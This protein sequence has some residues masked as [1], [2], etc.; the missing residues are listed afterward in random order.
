MSIVKDNRP[1]SVDEREMELIVGEQP[2]AMEFLTGFESTYMPDHDTDI[3][4]T[5]RHLDLFEH[6]LDLVAGAGIRALRYPVPWHRIEREPGRYDWSWMDSVMAAINHLGLDPIVDPVHHTSFPAWLELGFLDERF[7]ESYTAFVM[8]FA[9][10]YPWVRRY[11]PFN[12]PMPTTLFCAD[13]G[14]WKPY[15]QHERHWVKM[16]RNVAFAVSRVSRALKAADPGIEIVHVDTCEAHHAL[17]E[18]SVPWARF[19]NDRRFLLHD[20]ILGRVGPPHPLY[21]FVEEHGTGAEDGICEEDLAWLREN[22]AQIDV[23]GLDYYCHSEQQFHATGSHIPSLSP[24]GFA[25]VARQ[26]IERYN[27]PVM[28]TETNIRGYVSVPTG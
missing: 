26:Y 18:Q 28:L 7:V 12:E 4:E 9:E 6:D 15:H 20:L 11:T 16:A 24:Y 21:W 25:E 14:I 2:L 13:R 1:V 5:T 10:R 3:L 27:L 8:A 23:L 22:P 17:D 19:L